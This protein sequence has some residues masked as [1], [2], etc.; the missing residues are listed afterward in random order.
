MSVFCSPDVEIEHGHAVRLPPSTLRTAP[1]ALR[2]GVEDSRKIA[3][4]LSVVNDS[5]VPPPRADARCKRPPEEKTSVSSGPHDAPTNAGCGG[6]SILSGGPP[7]IATRTTPR[8]GNR[9]PI[10]L[11]SGEKKGFRV[12][13]GSAISVPGITPRLEPVEL[14]HVERDSAA[15][16]ILREVRDPL[17]VRRDR[18][19]DAGEVRE[20]RRG[21]RCDDEARH[22]QR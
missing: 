4:V 21:R 20:R 9:K 1:P 15:V 16:R 19:I 11:P 6:S 7:S 3:P 14:A 8:P 12:P 5:G 18:E 13:S 2:A 22:R 10:D 17:T